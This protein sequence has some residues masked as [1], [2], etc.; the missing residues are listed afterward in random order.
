[1]QT[2]WNGDWHLNVNVQMNYWPAEVCNLSEL[3]EPLFALI[4]SLAKSGEATAKKYYNARGWVAHVLSNPWGFTSPGEGADWGATTTGS[5]WLVTH[6]WEHYRFAG[7][8]EFL[9]RVYPWMKGSA[10]FYADMLIEEPSHRWLVTAPANSPENAF[11]MKDGTVAHICMGPTFDSQLLRYLFAATADAS[12]ELNMDAEFRREL[13]TKAARLP[14]TRIGSDGRVLEW[15]E[16]Y[17]EP[18][19]HHRHISHLWGLFPGEEITPAGS[20]AL[21]AAARKTLD[22]RGDGGTGWCLAHKLAL[23]ARLGDGSRASDILR[24]LLKPASVAD[25]INTHGGGT[26]ANLFDAHPPFQIDGNLGGAAAIAELLLQSHGGEMH[27]L[28][29]LPSSWREGEVR[30]LRARGGFEVDLAWRDGKLTRTEIRGA[31]GAKLRVRY[32][33]KLISVGR[34]ALDG[35]LR[36]M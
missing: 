9:K 1:V 11:R 8:R 16:E 32:G 33:G 20:P 17:E 21:A 12:A 6:L 30:G 19:P 10:Q 24:S 7:D 14:P 4:G 2:P 23:W 3:H 35:E 25:E 36:S 28:P 34:I 27:V 31:T 22:R 13:R 29:A 15:L 5:A 26:Y 18:D